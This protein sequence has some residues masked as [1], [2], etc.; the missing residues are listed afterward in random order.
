MAAIKHVVWNVIYYLEGARGAVHNKIQIRALYLL[1]IGRRD[2]KAGWKATRGIIV[3]KPRW[4]RIIAQI[5]KKKADAFLLKMPNNVRYTFVTHLSTSTLATHVLFFKDGGMIALIPA[6]EYFRTKDE[7]DHMEHHVFGNLP[8]VKVDSINM[9][10]ALRTVLRGRKA[11]KVLCDA[12]ETV[13]GVRFI[14]DD[15]VTK[16]RAI[17]TPSEVRLVRKAIAITDKAGN[18]L[19][20]LSKV[21]ATERAVATEIDLI[22]RQAGADRIGFDSIVAAGAHSAYSHHDNS[23]YRFRKGDP[24]IYDIGAI[25]KGYAAD[26]SR[27]L[28]VGGRP[29]LRELRDVY[30]AVNEGLKAS[31]RAVRPG[32]R[33]CDVDQAARDVIAEYGYGRYFVHSTGHGIGLEVHEHPYVSPSFKDRLKKGMIFTI[34]PGVYLPGKGGVRIENDVLL[35]SSGKAVTLNRT[36]IMSY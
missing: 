22:M 15:L 9:A 25:Y 8:G 17:K 31:T 23:N 1:H 36:H 34:E 32:A 33:C 27:T 30:H 3:F 19:P 6:L 29:R 7:A 16:M 35:A 14:C 18:A 20:Q 11:R 26:M 5:H 2:G 28:F 13:K 21:G 10:T 24:V 4:R 12:C